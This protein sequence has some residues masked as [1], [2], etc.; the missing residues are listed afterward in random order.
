MAYI[1]T[2]ARPVRNLRTVSVNSTSNCSYTR[3]ITSVTLLR[4]TTDRR[5]VP[6][7]AKPA[8]HRSE[9]LNGHFSRK[10]EAPDDWSSSQLS[11]RIPTGN[12]FSLLNSLHSHSLS[13]SDSPGVPLAAHACFREI[14]ENFL[15]RLFGDWPSMSQWLSASM[16]GQLKT[17]FHANGG[18][19]FCWF[20]FYFIGTYSSVVIAVIF[21]VAVPP[22]VV[23]RVFL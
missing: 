14:E 10:K 21:T 1:S 13:L 22:V 8:R 19:T 11:S 2:L 6:A 23:V 3:L 16:L 9:R 12:T 20:L 5:R 4:R 7:A 17:H 15:R 18:C